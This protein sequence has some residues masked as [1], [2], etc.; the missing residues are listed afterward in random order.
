MTTTDRCREEFED[1]VQ[2]LF[3]RIGTPK[4]FIKKGEYNTI[5]FQKMHK[6]WAL[7][8]ISAVKK[9]LLILKNSIDMVQSFDEFI[10]ISACYAVIEQEFGLQGE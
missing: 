3:P 9:C 8:E 10:E 6:L 4:F 2:K 7:A 5:A 1:A